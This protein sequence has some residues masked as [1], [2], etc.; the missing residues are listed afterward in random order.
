MQNIKEYTPGKTHNNA[1]I[2]RK[3]LLKP[4]LNTMHNI[5]HTV[6]KPYEY[7]Q[8]NNMFA[9]TRQQVIHTTQEKNLINAFS[10]KIAYPLSL[11]YTIYVNTYQEKAS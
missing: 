10:V 3:G 5:M 2:V 9:S 11:I 8:C 6:D 1:N 4:A 7:K